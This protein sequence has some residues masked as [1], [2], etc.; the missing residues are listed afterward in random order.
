M[1][2]EEMARKLVAYQQFMAKYIVEAQ[3]SKAKAV[4]AAENAV[5]QKYEEKL[6]LLQ[7]GT[8]AAEPSSVQAAPL[9]ASADTK[10][11]QERSEKVSAAA[12]AGKSRW[13]DMEN[14]RAAQATASVAA[15]APVPVVQQ[16]KETA[17][18]VQTVGD[19]SLYDNRNAMVAAAG[20]AGKS[21]WGEMEVMKATAASVALPSSPAP[22]AVPA[23]A[24]P[25]PVA[26]TNIPV[27]PEVAAADHGLRN[28]GGVGGP[29]L[30]ERINLGARLLQKDSTL[31]A[32][33]P[34][35][36]ASTVITTSAPGLSLYEKRNMMVAAA[37]KAGKSRWGEFEIK[38]AKS[39]AAALPSAAGIAQSV[40]AVATPPEV[41]AAD[42]G[43]RNDGGVG[44][45]SLAE[46]VNL[47]AALLGR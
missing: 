14:Q 6:L 19:R 22:A 8:K 10:L 20:K 29:S 3:Q 21:R 24:S 2:K 7:G 45:P 1:S 34:A 5:R 38:K 41:A 27:P 23:K 46:R 9:Q 43:L 30:A 40:A 16:V 47:G 39:L 42:H 25:V 35:P 28:D 12:K 26:A 11:Y 33:A 13:G 44:G 18:E 37:A 4:I 32:P 31:L 17:I 36:V 15:P